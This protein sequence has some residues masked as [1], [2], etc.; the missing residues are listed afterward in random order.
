MMRALWDE[1]PLAVQIACGFLLAMGVGA[2]VEWVVLR[3]R[4]RGR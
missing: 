4:G 3:A 1:L 2:L